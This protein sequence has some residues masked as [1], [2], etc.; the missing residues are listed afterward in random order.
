MFLQISV[1]VPGRKLDDELKEL[2]NNSVYYKVTNL[3]IHH[4][5]EPSFMLS[6]ARKGTLNARTLHTWPDVDTS[7]TFHSGKLVISVGKD[8]YQ[9][10][11]LNGQPC[12]TLGREV[13][14]YGNN[15][16]ASITHASKTECC[17]SSHYTRFPPG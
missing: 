7:A 4:F 1:V 5:L 3:P 13:A 10:L 15:T 17:F 11:G 16:C 9:E 2:L 12:L 14:S 6:F 8:V